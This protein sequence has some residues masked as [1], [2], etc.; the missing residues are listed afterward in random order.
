MAM[1]LLTQQTGFIGSL[2]EVIIGDV[3]K[4]GT[5]N[6]SEIKIIINYLTEYSFYVFTTKKNDIEEAEFIKWHNQYCDKF[7]R[8]ISHN[9]VLIQLEA[10]G[11]FRRQEDVIG[12]KYKYYY[13]YFVAKYLAN[14]IYDANIFNIIRSLT[15]CLHLDDAANIM[16][17][18]CHFS[19]DPRILEMI[20]D[21][22]KMHFQE[23]SEFDLSKSPHILSSGP[24]DRTDLSL[25]S[26]PHQ[27][28]R[29]IALQEQDE[30]SRPNGLRELDPCLVA[31]EDGANEMSLVNEVSSGSHLIRICG[32]IIRNFYGDMPGEAQVAIIRECY[33]LSLRIMSVLFNYMEVDKDL[34]SETVS[35]I[36]QQRNPGL[37]GHELEQSVK[38]TLRTVSLQIS[39]GYVK[40]V[41]NSIGLLDLIE[42]F[43]KVLSL[44]GIGVSHKLLDISTRL[45][46]FDHFP[47]SKIMDVAGKIE[48]TD[49]GFEVLRILVWEHFKLFKSD[50][51]VRQ[52]ICN[53]L[54][55]KLNE[56]SFMN[57]KDK[58]L[59]HD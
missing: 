12:F 58:K 53:K 22:V 14:H 48:R 24:I 19:K 26:T 27:G 23:D 2:Y 50:Y 18:L 28:E 43:D 15:S 37:S 45:D 51:K 33:G 25:S 21:K 4:D 5:S 36:L 10:I 32:Q 42:S 11:V 52:R 1:E 44:E 47:E 9:E 59:L 35:K 31:T 6:P 16:L 29:I 55:I 54:D 30:I 20:L 17:F 39:Y 49:I 57:I 3:I 40:H 56:P 13:W 46:F 38:R 34:I 41:S 7:N 8:R